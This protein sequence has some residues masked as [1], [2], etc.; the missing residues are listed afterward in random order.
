[1]IA[2]L[3]LG[4]GT[5]LSYFVESLWFGSLGFSDVF[6]TTLNVQSVVF[7]GFSVVT[8]LILYGSFLALKPARL[9]ELSS[10]IPDQRP[11]VPPPG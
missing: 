10:P 5:A 11:A 3:L 1:M 8:F 2:V 7:T 9:A 6:W 4:G